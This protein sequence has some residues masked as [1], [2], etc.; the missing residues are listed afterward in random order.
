M[1]V[2]LRLIQRVNK[3]KQIGPPSVCQLLVIKTSIA[4]YGDTPLLDIIYTF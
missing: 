2:P 3:N 4:C 1:H